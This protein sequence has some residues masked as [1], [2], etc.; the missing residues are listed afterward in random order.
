MSEPVGEGEIRV[1]YFVD[2]VECDL[3]EFLRRAA[4]FGGGGAS[5]D[6]QATTIH[7]TN[8]RILRSGDRLQS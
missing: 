3:S 6:T 1:A 5:G 4:R 7:G 8:G 2:G